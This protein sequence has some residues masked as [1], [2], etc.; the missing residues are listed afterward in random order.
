MNLLIVDIESTA[1]SPTLGKAC[2]VG[3]I[4]YSVQHQTVLQAVSTLLPVSSNPQRLLNGIAEDATKITIPRPILESLS[5]LITLSDCMVAHNAE[6]DRQWFGID[7]LPSIDLPWICTLFDFDW[8][9]TVKPTNLRDL[10]LAHGIGVT[11]A[12]RSL[13]DCDLIA[14]LFSRV[15][16]LEVRI[17]KAMQPRAIVEA[18]VTFQQRQLAKDAGFMAVYEGDRFVRWERRM[19]RSDIASLPF[20]VKILREV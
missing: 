18:V 11:K 20:T 14:E 13:T 10:A 19:F 3:A 2:E 6:F 8:P 15:D 16:D 4:L 17:A 1:E 7:P 9:R 12:H 5:M